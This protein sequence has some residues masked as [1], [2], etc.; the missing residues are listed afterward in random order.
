MSDTIKENIIQKLSE[1]LARLLDYVERTR[2]GLETIETTVIEGSESVPQASVQISAVTGD[3]ENAANTIMTILE[4]VLTEHDKNH[5][6]IVSLSEW[7]AGL[8]EKDREQGEAIINEVREINETNKK[9]M[10]DIFSNMSFH[11]LS[12]QKLKKVTMSL[13]VVQ[14]KLHEIAMSFGIKEFDVDGKS[15]APSNHNGIVNDPMDQDIV[16]QLLKELGT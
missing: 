8:S 10:M 9:R 11:D 2:S 4:D 5:A 3:L 15:A 12:G 13:A 7:A 14:A 16:D 1:E 6:L